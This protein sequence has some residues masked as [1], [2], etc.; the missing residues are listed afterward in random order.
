[1]FSQD[2]Y[3]RA[4]LFAAEA[5]GEQKYP[6][7]EMPYITHIGQVAMEVIVSLE[8]DPADNPDLAVQCALLHDVIE[9]TH[10][11]VDNVEA[12]FGPDVLAGVLALTKDSSLKTKPERM[13]DS[14]N[15]IQD[16]PLEVWRVKL[17]DR[18]SNLGQPPHYWSA[19]KISNYQAEARLIYDALHPASDYL[20]ER[21]AYKID[22][23][24]MWLK[25]A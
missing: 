16:Q 19:T 3:T 8:A 5:H 6:G 23:Y 10:V 12:L 4:W 1:M 22:Q 14:L 20:A 18:I 13:I 9:D 7:S 17:A 25:G 21:L 2:G 15:R 11:E 24:S